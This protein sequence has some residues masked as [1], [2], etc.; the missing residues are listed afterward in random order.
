MTPAAPPCKFIDCILC[1]R[2]LIA[3]DPFNS[4]NRTLDA[5]AVTNLASRFSGV[6]QQKLAITTHALITTAM[7]HHKTPDNRAFTA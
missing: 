4:K 5:S 7:P 6:E 1:F 2:K 3:L